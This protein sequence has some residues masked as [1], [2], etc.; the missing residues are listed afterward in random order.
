MLKT[1]IEKKHYAFAKSFDSWED[2]ITASLQPL[3]ND[4]TVEPVYVKA[5]INCVHEYGPYIV[6]APNVAM[7]HATENA[8]GVNGTAIS[9]MRVAE[10]VEFDKDDSSKNARLFFALASTD[11]DK[12][13]ENISKLSEILMNEEL[14]AQLL[15]VQSVDD[16]IK[17][18]NKY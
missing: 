14:V 6:I 4:N 9:F 7:P 3:V 8:D 15:E 13:M 5:V 2:A 17:L 11:S 1:I 12:H 10:P 16:L 18:A